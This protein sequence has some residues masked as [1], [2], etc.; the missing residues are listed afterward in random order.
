MESR[1]NG[2]DEHVCKEEIDTYVENR[3]MDTKMG[4]EGG[5]IYW[6]MEIGIPSLLIL[7]VIS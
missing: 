1:K 7:R 2:I 6:E 5:G 3:C 4:K